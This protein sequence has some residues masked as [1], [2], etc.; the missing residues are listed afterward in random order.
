MPNSLIRQIRTLTALFFSF[1]ALCLCY[2]GA[3]SHGSSPYSNASNVTVTVHYHPTFGSPNDALVT[4]GDNGYVLVSVSGVDICHDESCAGVEVFK[5][6]DFTNPCGGQEILYFPRPTI[7]GEAVHSVDGMQFFPGPRQVSVG[8]AV[9][10]QG[11]E[12][13]RLA[14]LNEPC[15]I[16]GIINVQQPP[17]IPNCCHTHCPPGTFDLAVTPDG[18]P[19]YAFVANEYGVMPNPPPAPC[20]TPTPTP[21]PAPINTGVGTIGIIRVQRDHAGGFTHGTRAIGRNP[22]IYIPGGSAIPGVTMSHDGRYLYVTSEGSEEGFY[23]GTQIRY[24]DPTDV[25]D[26]QN[27]VVLCPGCQTGDFGNYCDNESD[28]QLVRNGLLTVI[29]VHKA[30]NGAGQASIVTV[31]AAGCSP[32]RAVE[33]TDGKYVWVA[34][35]GKNT[36]NPTEPSGYQVL[37]FD[38][39]KLVSASP[40][41]AFV[42]YGDSGGTAPVGMALFN[43]DSLLAVANSNRFYRNSECV[44]HPENC[45]ASVAILDVSNPAAPT[46]QQIIPNAPHAFPRNVTLGPDGST[47]YVPNANAKR[48]EVIETSVVNH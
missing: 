6:S 38:R 11:A 43:N 34:A 4:P 44:A 9:E 32:V 35:R 20:G 48:L 40:N 2:A 12:F 39:S 33:T 13:F 31:I 46:I 27:G 41:D 37:S 23:P 45:T 14:S 16:D 10:E 28:G 47:L 8:A 25:G 29:D 5:K 30:R 21:S 1:L 7:R 24:R 3:V 18:A 17:V 36:L 26:T 15:G 19:E 42:G 22:Y